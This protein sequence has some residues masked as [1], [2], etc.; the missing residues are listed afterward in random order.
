MHEL[1]I[2]YEKDVNQVKYFNELNS[3][4]IETVI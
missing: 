2:Q 4:K 1:N 3:N